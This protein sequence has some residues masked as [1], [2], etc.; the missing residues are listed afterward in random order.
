MIQ[1]TENIV[2]NENEIREEFVRASGPGGQNVNR[3]ATA[4]QLRFDILNSASLPEDV[5]RR[6][7]LLG[8]RRVSRDGILIIDARRFR[9]QEKNRQDALER[10]VKLVRKAAERPT[11]RHRTK[12][13]AASR[14]KRIERKRNRSR[15][16]QQRQSVDP[17]KEG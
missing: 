2:L 6:L 3:V 17:G 7:L 11:L 4:V 5:R 13:T 9:T 16:K 14:R 15:L 1:V 10:L 12:P 8:G